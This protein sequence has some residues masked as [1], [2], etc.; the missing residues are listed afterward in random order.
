MPKQ[1]F[2]S[3]CGIQLTHSRRAVPG[4]GTILDLITPHECE[5]YA[6]KSNIDESPTVLDVIEGLRD[7]SKTTEAI[8]QDRHT[9]F[10]EGHDEKYGDRRDGIKTSTAPQSLQSNI[11]DMGHSAPD[12]DIDG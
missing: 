1:F 12:G 5:G 11:N 2:C 9:G 8:S 3:T 7:L 6:I 4:K 10:R